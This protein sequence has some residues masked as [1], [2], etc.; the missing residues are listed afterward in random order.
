MTTRVASPVRTLVSV[1]IAVLVAA[2]TI[3]AAPRATAEEAG[4]TIEFLNPSPGTSLKISD[5]QAKDPTFG[6]SAWVSNASAVKLVEFEMTDPVNPLARATTIGAATQVAPDTYELQWATPATLTDGRYTLRAIAYGESR[7][8]FVELDRDEETVTL[9]STNDTIDITSPVRNGQLGMFLPA[10][11]PAGGVI[12]AAQSSPNGWARVLYTTSRPGT[13]PAWKPCG[14]QPTK[15]AAD[16]VSCVLAAT[17]N[18][19]AITAIAAVANNTPYADAQGKD[20]GKE[21]PDPS[22]DQ[23]ADAV[24]VST[25]RQIPAALAID[26]LTKKY[27]ANDQGVFPCTDSISAV[28]TDQF[29]DGIFGANVDVHASGP[30]N[31]VYF[32]VVALVS[33]NQAPNKVHGG[34]EP[35]QNCTGAPTTSNEPQGVHR[36]PGGLSVKHIESLPTD[37]TDD[38]GRFPF[39]LFSESPGTTQITAWVD[40]NEDDVYCEGEPSAAA[41][42]G[43]GAD[44]A[45][46][47]IEEPAKGCKIEKI[48]RSIALQ[49]SKTKVTRGQKVVLA[50]AITSDDSACVASQAVKLQSRRPGSAGAFRTIARQRT[51]QVGVYKFALVARRSMDYRAVAPETAMCVKA[52]SVPTKVRTDT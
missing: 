8:S 42:I 10:G 13:E 43:W 33:K 24:R 6:L 22:A 9:L 16:G 32:E 29:G 47:T 14:A 20:T 50:G 15:K 28:L 21:Q 23:T 40:I 49:S 36:S 4:A 5:K 52:R 39:K 51:T 3:A 18:Y 7:D 34:T 27:T 30:T 19:S 1:L 12:E 37:G 38:A 2:A 31:G 26:P 44:A 25:Y 11:R 48:L 46:A 35:A 41:T 45:V 17:E